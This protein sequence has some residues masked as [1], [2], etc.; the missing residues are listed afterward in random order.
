MFDQIKK[1]L[2]DVTEA[3]QQQAGTLGENAKEKGYK[4]IEDWLQ[5]FPKLEVYGLKITS[6]SLSVAISP[7]L[8]VELRGR[9]ADFPKERLQEII[10]ENRNNPSLTMVFSTINTTYN[11]H[12]KIYATLD[13]PLIVRIRIKI[14]P[15][16]RVT[17]GMPIVQ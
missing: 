8:D 9:H 13:D 11:L 16:I 17:I 6:F 1:A 7:A 15:E 10:H 2:S 4:I 3:I 5:I 12:R 14:S